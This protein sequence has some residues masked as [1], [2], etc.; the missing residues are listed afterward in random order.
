MA[1]KLLVVVFLAATTLIAYAQYEDTSIID[2][3]MQEVARLQVEN[4]SLR[5]GYVAN[6]D[7]YLN[8]I[9]KDADSDNA[10]RDVKV[11]AIDENGK[12]ET[13]SRYES[14][15]WFG[16]VEV[17]GGYTMFHKGTQYW[18]VGGG[19]RFGF[20]AKK[21]EVVFSFDAGRAEVGKKTVCDGRTFIALQGEAKYGRELVM[22]RAQTVRMV[23][24]VGGGFYGDLMKLDGANAW[25]YG[26]G[27]LVALGVQHQ[28]KKSHV[29]Y[30]V[31]LEAHSQIKW[32]PSQFTETYDNT[33]ITGTNLATE[34]G[35]WIGVKATFDFGG[36]W[37][38]G[39]KNSKKEWEQK[40]YDQMSN[41]V[42]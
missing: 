18:T 37:T 19:A 7:D 15:G 29:R 9:I 28:A 8:T 32:S 33:V 30:S 21:N 1:K 4:D 24:Y 12:L 17:F 13:I 42:L 27:F 11:T 36:K 39:N 2:S 6:L 41:D 3:L 26:P 5:N 20:K 16:G 35:A 14:E 25:G 22:N 31:L 10:S 34:Y 23:L 40:Y 38:K